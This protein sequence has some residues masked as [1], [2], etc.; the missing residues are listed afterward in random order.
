MLVDLSHTIE[1]GTRTYPGLPAPAI[2]EFLSR[3]DSRRTYA[4]GTEFSIGRIDMVGNTGTYLDAPFHRYSGGDDL[5]AL[6]LD[7]IADL[8]GIV[9]RAVDVPERALGPELFDGR[10][11]AG[12]AVLVHSGWSRRWGAPG[13]FAGHPHLSAAAAVRLARERAAL[14]GID[15]LN[16]DGI[17]DGERPVHSILLAAGIPIVEHLTGLDRVPDGNFRFFAVPPR[18]KGLGTFPVRAFASF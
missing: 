11:L 2:S 10:D 17:Q 9:V 13:Y 1:N 16:V 14:V 12:R 5:A 4:P 18:V 6:A 3:E 7:R 8:P 15:S